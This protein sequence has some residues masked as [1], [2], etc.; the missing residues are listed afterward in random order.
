MMLLE[1]RSRDFQMKSLGHCFH[2]S[3]STLFFSILRNQFGNFV[4]L[5]LWQHLG[6]RGLSWRVE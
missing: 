4:E 5:R 1:L 2:I 3:S 6:V